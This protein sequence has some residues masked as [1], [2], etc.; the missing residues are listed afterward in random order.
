MR[1]TFKLFLK[2]MFF[3][4]IFWKCKIIAIRESTNKKKK[5][6]FIKKK[7]CLQYT[8]FIYIYIIIIYIYISYLYI[9]NCIQSNI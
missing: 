1:F 4:K 3:L 8:K 6:I 5:K 2:K 9:Y 7:K